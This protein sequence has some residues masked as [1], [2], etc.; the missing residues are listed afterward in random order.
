MKPITPAEVG[1]K[2]AE[3]IPVE[4]IEV[5]NELITKKWDGRQSIVLQKDAV[6]G[7]VSRMGVSRDQVYLNRW[8]DVE[9]AFRQAGWRVEYDKPGFNESYDASFT[10][11]TGK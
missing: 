6:A 5:F 11:K 7:I 3:S 8:L 2:K 4:V 10:F 1:K 9:G